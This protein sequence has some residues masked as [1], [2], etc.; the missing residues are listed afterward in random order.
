MSFVTKPFLQCLGLIVACPTCILVF[1]TS[2]GFVIK[3]AEKALSGPHMH[4]TSNVGTLSGIR[5]L[6]C[7]TMQTGSNQTETTS[8]VSTS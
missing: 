3:L 5:D 6:I 1:I 4:C 2:S 7:P 8:Y